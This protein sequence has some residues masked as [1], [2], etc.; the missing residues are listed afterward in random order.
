MRE[1]LQTKLAEVHQIESEMKNREINFET[2][3]KR[4][5]DDL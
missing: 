2:E 5:E 1:E 3:M 4:K